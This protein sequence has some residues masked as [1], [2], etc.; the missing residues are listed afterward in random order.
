VFLIVG[1]GNPGTRYAST[2]HNIGFAVVDDVA[3]D[4]D[5]TN[6]FDGAYAALLLG[7]E[8]VGLLRPQTFMNRSGRSVSAA[9]DFFKIPRENVLIVHDEL[10]LRFGEVRLK[11]G[12]GEAGHNGLRSVS[13]FLGSK[14]YHRL[15][16]GIGRPA[17][18]FRGDIADYVLQAFALDQVEAVPDLVQRGAD[19]ARLFIERGPEAAMNEINRKR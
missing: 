2:R 18:D 14:D 8:R 13:Q 6:R 11:R 17:D 5:W 19:A 16:I 7:S 12:G 4:T 1:L 10:D 9:I 15:R 3:R